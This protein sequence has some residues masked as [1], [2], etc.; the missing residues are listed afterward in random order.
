[1]A[2]PIEVAAL[3]REIENL[4][5][6]YPELAEDETL[7]AD[8]IAGSTAAE[9]VLSALTSRI[10][11]AQAMASAIVKRKND[12]DARLTACERREEAYRSL[13]LRVMHAAQLRKMPLPEATLSLRAVPPAVIIS[14]EGLIPPAFQKVKTSP[15]RAKIKEALQAGEVVPGARLSNGSESLSVRVK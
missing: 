1:M 3:E 13:A 10:L 2:H 8:M 6:A 15:D 7:R 11:D 5:A 9:E 4:I 12:L 14:D